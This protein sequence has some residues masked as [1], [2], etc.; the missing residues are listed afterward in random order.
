MKQYIKGFL[1]FSAGTWIRAVVSFFSTPVISYLIVPEEF[2]RAAIFTLFYNIALL[3][4][5]MGL[6]QSYVRYY[7]QEEKKSEL[8]W[9]CMFLPFV[10]GVSVSF[11]F[12][13]FESP[14]NIVLYGKN[15]Q[16]I[17]F[18][19]S[20]SL[21][22]GILQRFN[23]L[24][25]RMQKRGLL[26]SLLDIA[27]SL[28]NVGGSIVFAVVVSRN[29]YA[30]VFGQVTG[31]ILALSL[32]FIIDRESRK[33]S[34]VNF[35]NI[36]ELLKYGFPLLPTSLL[37][38]LFSSIDRISLRQY[39]NFTEIGLYS[40]AFK[41][42]SV[43]QLFQT[44]FTTFWV[45]LAYEKF[46]SQTNSKEFFKKANRA[47]SFAIFVFGFL[48]L[49]FK[50]VI[51]LLFEKSYR[52]ASF[53]A[54]FLILQPVMY[55]ISETTVLGINFTKKTYWHIV[56]TGISAFANFAGNQLLVPYFGAKG[57]A[58]ST[59]LSYI[60]FFTLRTS[61]AEKL[62]PVGFDLKKI[63]IGTLVIST[64]AFFGTFLKNIPVF[65]SVCTTGIFLVLLLYR[66]EITLLKNQLKS[67]K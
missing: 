51:F 38:W 60:V 13:F 31:N 16:G 62:Y 65:L 58:V 59:G 4:S 15:Y 50:D 35:K 37:F 5:L 57:A 67:F 25:I 1:S 39:S 17:G 66:S 12:I 47:V 64:V 33:L 20:I 30:I 54:P 8:F 22:T 63:Y 42:V 6:D 21:M 28:G 40:A 48:V 26:Y 14:F 36:G 2:G 44:G 19:F 11:I 43:M 41:I 52:D 10:L 23:Q 53:I 29:F 34:K 49:A 61:I 3:V 32:G 24:S 46:E 56:V 55:V 18:L 9:S 7:Y 27:N 45:P